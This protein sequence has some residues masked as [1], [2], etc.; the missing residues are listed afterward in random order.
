MYHLR[1]CLWTFRVLYN[2][3]R[4]S[5]VVD[6]AAISLGYLPNILYLLFMNLST[7]VQI[8]KPGDFGSFQRKCKVLFELVLDDPNAKEFGTSGQGQDGIDILGVRR[9]AAPDHWVGIQCKLT[10]KSR[11]LKKGTIRK[12]AQKALAI[13]PALKELIVVTTAEDD[14]EMD[15]EAAAVTDEQAKKGRDF[16]V[17]VWGWTT[18]ETKIL[19]HPKALEAFMPGMASGQVELLE[20]QERILERVESGNAGLAQQLQS[21]LERLDRQSPTA[22]LAIPSTATDDRFTTRYDKEID[23]YRD[24]LTSGK[25]KT[26]CDLLETLWSS[27]TEQDD[28]RIRFRVRSNMGACQVRLGEIEAAAGLYLESYTFDPQNP[29]ACAMKVLGHI[30]NEDFQTA[31]DF[32]VAELANHPDEAALYAHAILAAKYLGCEELPFTASDE[33]LSS[34]SVVTAFAEFL[35]GNGDVE[36]ARTQIFRAIERS[37]D[38]ENI[39]RQW[40]EFVIEDATAWVTGNDRDGLPLEQ[41]EQLRRAI[42]TLDALWQKAA[43]SEAPVSDVSLTLCNN[44]AVAHRI[45]AEPSKAEQVIAQGLRLDPE[46]PHLMTAM[47]AILLEQ[48][49]DDEA[50]DLIQHVPQSRDTVVARAAIYTN[51]QNWENLAEYVPEVNTDELEDKD[52]ATLLTLGLIA[53]FKLGLVAD[54]RS[55]ARPLLDRYPLEPNVPILLHQ[56]ALERE[57]HGEWAASMFQ[58]AL[59]RSDYV[60]FSSRRMLARAAERENRPD[61]VVELLTGRVDVETDGPDLRMLARAFVNIPVSVYALQFANSISDNLRNTAFYARVVASINYNA[62][63]LTEAESNFVTAAKGNPRDLSAHIGLLSTYQRED[64][65]SEIRSHIGA[66]DIDT[67]DGSAEHFMTLAQIFARYGRPD[68]ALAL[69]YRT[70]RDNWDSHK[71]LLGYVGLILPEPVAPPIPPT[72]SFIGI[73]EWVLLQSESG[74]RLGVT[75]EEG[76]D[77]PSRDIYSPSH[78]LAQVLLGSSVGDKVEYNPASGANFRWEIIDRRHKYL[79]LLHSIFENF[80]MQFPDAQG[81]RQFRIDGGDITPIL[82]QVK[83]L[84]EQDQTVV[85]WYV[86]HSLPISAVAGMMGKCSVDFAGRLAG[87]GIPIRVCAGTL[88][89]RDAAIQLLQEATG[90]GIALDTHAA[91][92][93]SVLGLTDTLKSLYPRVCITQSVLDELLHWR[94]DFES[95]G[96]QPIMTMGYRDG[97][98]F[99][100]EMAPEDV[101]NAIQTIQ[102]VIDDMRANLEIAP[103]A[104]PGSLSETEERLI[105]ISGRDIFDPIY[106]AKNENLLLVSEDM[107]FRAIGQEMQQVSGTWLQPMLMLAHDRNLLDAKRY[108]AAISQLALRRHSHLSLRASDLA[109]V[110]DLDQTAELLL[111][112]QTAGFIGGDNADVRSHFNVG[113][114]FLQEVWGLQLP[115]LKKAQAVGF[116][117]ERIAVMLARHGIL[118]KTFQEMLG[119]SL[120]KPLADYLDRWCR[121]HFIFAGDTER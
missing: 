12:E 76:Q 7:S 62:G 38:D 75:I 13:T 63:N 88:A 67:L 8:P 40:A 102:G 78:P 27:L 111:F 30:L 15:R 105:E 115:Y 33:I 23:R 6:R 83:E 56:A 103:A 37:P 89:E 86:S 36:A 51:M 97:E 31:L 45:N 3:G 99:R 71:V 1:R 100:E 19:Q 79:G 69:G 22:A 84:G 26:A 94:F 48:G 92:I 29:R 66:L 90:T 114:D 96:D 44:L 113:L 34:P 20:G 50:V 14:T 87:S 43:G 32:A 73:D 65:I 2:V 54:I 53:R 80:P 24:I 82:K 101:A 59:D 93:V 121:G 119:S 64:K 104:R 39:Q 18:L 95:H 16:R 108:A 57:D 11:K 107:S 28:P 55:E 47:L 118:Q 25:P 42:S 91:W 35:R 52:A 17:S 10:I 70:A 58:T 74:Q 120:N 116:I 117:L 85:D 9:S 110:L 77:R 49:K 5:S 4:E 106:A 109:S 21:V 68:D 72:G 98:Y 61:V 112:R 46:N 60:D 41:K 81:F